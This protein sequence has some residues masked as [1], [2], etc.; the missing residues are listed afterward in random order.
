MEQGSIGTRD[1]QWMERALRLAVLARHA[2]PNPSVGC[3][4][5]S[6]EG[7][8]VGE[9]YTQPPGGAHAEV[10][11]LRMAGE[12]ARGATAYVTLEPC[13]HHGRTP[14]CADALIASHVARVVAAVPDPDVAGRGTRAGAS[15]A[16]G[17]CCHCGRGGRT[18]TG[19]EQRHFSSTGQQGCLG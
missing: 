14:P 11:A 9:G 5:V 1:K 4:L 17:D 8:K 10:M 6:P 12:R 18:G 13:A 2:S 19:A 16:G 3:V 7:V 15:G